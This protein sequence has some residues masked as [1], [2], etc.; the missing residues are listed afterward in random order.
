MPNYNVT[1]KLGGG[2][3]LWAVTKAFEALDKGLKVA[4]NV[5]LFPEKI[6]RPWR[7]QK[8]VQLMRLPD[9]PSRDDMDV[10]G[11][12]NV[13]SDEGQN[14]LLILDECGT[15]LN[16][17]SYKE[18]GRQDLINWFLHARKLG[19]DV[20]FISQSANMIDKQIRDALIE[21]LVV[22]K[23]FDRY[24]IPFLPWLGIKIKLPRIHFA[25][26]KYGNTSGSM[27]AD[28]DFFRG[29]GVFDAYSTRQV[30]SGQVEGVYSVL[31]PWHLKGRFMTPT[32]LAKFAAK[33]SW[34]AGLALGCLATWIFYTASGY[35][36][37][38]KALAVDFSKLPLAT[39][40]IH[41]P[42]GSFLV[43]KPDGQMEVTRSITYSKE[44]DIATL[45]TGSFR[46]PKANP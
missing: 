35:Q 44:G 18:A 31:S 19:W 12:G 29:K 23:R 2:K 32:Q 9:Y 27:V 26:I 8:N 25:I 38:V 3:T 40:V 36:K 45:S 1:G 46:I 22:C 14:G 28:R 34:V 20:M 15:M 43:I 41:Q 4:S 16:A 6:L 5:D 24:N 42:D 30:I 10:L 33:T 17:R 7:T 13:T 11:V 37:P 21:Y 39:G